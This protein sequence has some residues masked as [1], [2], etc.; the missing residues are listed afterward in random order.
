MSAEMPAPMPVQP[1]APAPTTRKRDDSSIAR[2]IL[3]AI[4]VIVGCLAIALGN[5]YAWAIRTTLTTDAW[6]A[7]TSPL[8]RD[9]AVQQAI[10]TLVVEKIDAAVDIEG[11]VKERIPDQLDPIAA[12]VAAAVRRAVEQ[13]VFEFLASDGF[14]NAWDTAMRE[15]HSSML[16][17]VRDTNVDPTIP[18]KI[19]ALVGAIDQRLS[20]LGID[21][22]PGDGP[23]SLGA[24]AIRVEGRFAQIQSLIGWAERL[25]WIVPLVALGAFALA[26]FLARRRGRLFVTIAA[27]TAVVLALELGAFRI[28]EA[29]VASAPQRPV[30]AAGVEAMLSILLA[31]LFQQTTTL[32]VLAIV[33]AVAAWA[34][35]A[36]TSLEP[37]RRF[38]VRYAR[39]L[40][41]VAAGIA[42]AYV[43][44][45]PDLTVARALLVLA[46]AA[47]A[48]I[49]VEA[50]LRDYSEG[51]EPVTVDAA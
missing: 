19:D 16:T 48:V 27:S 11:W 18:L 25:V 14:A 3:I 50:V 41:V 37:V 35:R 51:D 36:A 42:L 5:F 33:I 22:F 46:L 21:L 6:V 9:P 26:L 10:G 13:A 44:L 8:A 29:E 30:M 20:A 2:R 43:L 40:Q 34:A 7:A 28:L 38:V 15:G 1:A 31:G 24:V 23:P 45:G 32:L 47:A 39:P 49:G 4:L 17:F 12:A